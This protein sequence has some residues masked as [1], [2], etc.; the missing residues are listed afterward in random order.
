MTT[1][2]VDDGTHQRLLLLKQEWGAGSLDQ[3]IRRL[4]D[5]AK[6]V[7]KSM[8]GVDP[9]LPRLTRA[10]RNEIGGD[11]PAHRYRRT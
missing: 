11:T 10:L 7:P 4:L 5:Q 6:P 8:M 9:E 1:V 2:A 3:V